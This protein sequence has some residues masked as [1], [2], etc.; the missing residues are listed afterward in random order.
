V[1][2]QP[3]AGSN[4][5]PAQRWST[6]RLRISVTIRSVQDGT[7]MGIID[8]FTSNNAQVVSRRC[9]ADA[10]HQRFHFLPPGWLSPVC[11]AIPAFIPLTISSTLNEPKA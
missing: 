2:L 8:G 4:G 3:C 10:R 1:I 6:D 5:S 9:E 11:P 7:C